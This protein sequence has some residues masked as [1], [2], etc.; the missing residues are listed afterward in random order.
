MKIVYRI[1]FV[2]LVMLG[3]AQS[4]TIYKLDES[5][6]IA[7]LIIVS[8]EHQRNVAQERVRILEHAIIEQNRQCAD[9]E[10]RFWQGPYYPEE[11]PQENQEDASPVSC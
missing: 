6:D 10:P 7:A 2:L 8:T 9:P 4:F 5:L 1:L 11:E 3:A